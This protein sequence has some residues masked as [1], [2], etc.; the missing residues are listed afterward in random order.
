[1]GTP[2]TVTRS[3]TIAAPADRVR[4]LLTDFHEWPAWSPWEGIDPGMRRTYSGAER[5]V[6]ACF[7]WEGNRKAGK[8]SMTITSDE[9]ERV[10]IA[11]RFDKPFR[12]DNRIEFILGPAGGSTA[13]EWRM[14]GELSPVMR[15]FALVKSM[16]SLVGPDFEKGLAQLTSVAEAG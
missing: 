13:V 1:M 6:G 11:L 10:D 14:H 7:T 2:Y 8:G 9:P 16:D 4:A 15:V 3:T 5:S 12:A